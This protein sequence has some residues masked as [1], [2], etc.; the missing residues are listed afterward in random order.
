M[1]LLEKVT[2]KVRN[3]LFYAYSL[4]YLQSP[5]EPEIHRILYRLSEVIDT[6]FFTCNQVGD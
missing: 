1:A 5:K 3:S 2:Q 4:T 6:F